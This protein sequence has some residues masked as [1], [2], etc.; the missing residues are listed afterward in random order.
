VIEQLE[1]LCLA[2]GAVGTTDAKR[3]VNA[4]NRP[5]SRLLDA[6]IV[7]LYWARDAE[8]GVILEPVG[9]ENRSNAPDP[10]DFP[11]REGAC[12]ILEW[13]YTNGKPLWLE[14]MRRDAHEPTMLNRANDTEIDVAE[15]NLKDPP[16]SDATIVVPIRERGVVC[17]LYSVEMQKSGRLSNQVLDLLTKLGRSLGALLY[18]VDVYDYDLRKTGR[19]IQAFESTLDG[20]SFDRVLIEQSYRTA[21]VARPYRGEFARVQTAIERALGRHGIRAKHY[22]PDSQKYIVSEIIEQIRSAHFC[23]VDLT[24]NNPNVV[25]EVGMMMGMGKRPLVLKQRG[26]DAEVPFDLGQ[27]SVW[28][29]ELTADE[30]LLVH[31]PADHQ[32]IDLDAVLER[33]LA[34]LPQDIGFEA[35]QE[36]REE[37]APATV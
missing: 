10:R 17:G 24:G 21:F 1:Q 19:A 36:W 15:L 20:F 18:N 13:V 26:D 5:V 35:A 14:E 37:P 9:F 23:V 30:K 4:V 7:K 34:R 8:E 27:F 28:E 12:G 29:Y 2:A 33:F 32:L 6:H 3:V 11:V 22:M 31:S 25:A 16:Q